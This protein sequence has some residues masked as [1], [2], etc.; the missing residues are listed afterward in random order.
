MMILGLTG[1]VAMGKS[2]VASQ[3]AALGAATCN[4]DAIVHELLADNPDVIAEIT[5]HFPSAVEGGVINRKLLGNIVFSDNARLKVLESILHPRVK[6]VEQDF[7]KQA[8][9]EG[10]WLVVLDI[11]LL[12]E[13]EA[14]KRCDYVAVVTAAYEIQ[15]QRV[16]A[17][18][19]MT[20]EKFARILSYQ[21]PDAEKRKR[22][23][24]IIHTD[25]G[26]EASFSEVRKIVEIL[27]EKRH[28]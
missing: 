15:K 6:R 2:T 4:A 8:E 20:E 18:P 5:R 1:S 16:M 13:T 7:A 12:Y 19:D 17:R 14:E 24:F 10:K 9:Q 26:L 3:F 28:A 23:D 27:K 21:M 11:P 25:N 22:A